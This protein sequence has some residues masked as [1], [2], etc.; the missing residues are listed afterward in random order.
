M[1]NFH[2][3]I[4]KTLM[5]NFVYIYSKRR[6]LVMFIL[7]QRWQFFYPNK[8]NSP[9]IRQ[10]PSFLILVTWHVTWS[11]HVKA[12]ENLK[13]CFWGK[14]HLVLGLLA[15]D[16]ANHSYP[17]NTSLTQALKPLSYPIWIS[18]YKKHLEMVVWFPD[19]NTEVNGV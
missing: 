1:L 17:Q 11:C 5:L 13:I 3:E 18:T 15:I 6:K 16:I 14:N 12:Q 10:I 9:P 7:F 2:L 8:S 4:F 19:F